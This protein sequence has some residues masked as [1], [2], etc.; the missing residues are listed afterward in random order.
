MTCPFK[1]HLVLFIYFSQRMLVYHC[2]ILHLYRDT[3]ISIAVDRG[4]FSTELHIFIYHP[5]KMHGK[6]WYDRHMCSSSGHCL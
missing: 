5:V 4:I 1:I 6:G 2:V 3:L